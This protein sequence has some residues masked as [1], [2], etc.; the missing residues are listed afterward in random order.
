MSK[1]TGIQRTDVKHVN[2][3]TD[4]MCVAVVIVDIGMICAFPAC[5]GCHPMNFS[6]AA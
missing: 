3:K 2:D 4:K 5:S 6:T 1:G